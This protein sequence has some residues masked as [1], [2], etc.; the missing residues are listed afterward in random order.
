MSTSSAVPTRS[1]D[2]GTPGTPV[3]KG[4]PSRRRGIPKPARRSQRVPALV[5]AVGGNPRARTGRS[6][7]RGV[8]AASQ[9]VTA[10]TGS[11]RP[12]L[13]NTAL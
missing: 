13:S 2:R 4:R 1:L 12:A 10:P 9:T 6:Y 11:G 8:T 3:Q 5:D 7:C